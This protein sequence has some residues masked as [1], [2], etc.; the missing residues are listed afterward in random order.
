MRA[1]VA[2]YNHV[3]FEGYE[4][5]TVCTKRVN[6]GRI[7]LAQNDRGGWRGASGVQYSHRDFN[8]VG[9]E[10]FVPRNLT[11]QFALFTLQE[12]TAGPLGLEAAAR[13]EKTNVRT[14]E[15][16]VGKECVSTC[17]SRWSP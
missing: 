5:G 14:E 8:A 2:D 4:V 17:R 15:R 7:E 1:G 16:R 10:A 11:D 6:E 12:Y 9:A 3:E 13:Y